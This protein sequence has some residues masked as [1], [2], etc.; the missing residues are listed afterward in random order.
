MRTEITAK[1]LGNAQYPGNKSHP[2]NTKS[3]NNR[4]GGRE[5]NQDQGHRKYF[6]IKVMKKFSTFQKEVPIKL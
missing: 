4:N 5:R 2:G 6:S 3:V 1:S